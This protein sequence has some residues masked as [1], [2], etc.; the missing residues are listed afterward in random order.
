MAKQPSNVSNTTTETSIVSETSAHSLESELILKNKELENKI[1]NL[2]LMMEQFLSSQIKKEEKT[3]EEIIEYE[4]QI[5]KPQKQEKDKGFQAYVN[6]DHTKRILLMN[7]MHAGGTFTTHSNK[8]IRF[9]HFG[10]IQHAR[11][12]DVESLAS[13]YRSYFEK[14]EIRIL[15]DDDAVE[16]LYLKESYNKY[17]I[18]KEELENIIELDAQKIV[19]KIKSL[20]EPMQE[21]ALSLIVSNVS[22]S[23]PKFMDKNKWEII[24]NAFG[25]NIQEF[26]NKYI[27]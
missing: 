17:D 24:N 26:A 6:I 21:S 23:N 7:M 15:N 9:N 4:K 14:L 5:A 12:E 27:G 22:K 13:K 25:I 2:T 19:E 18:S 10:H 20:S 11:F 3:N 16:A 8:P 1:N